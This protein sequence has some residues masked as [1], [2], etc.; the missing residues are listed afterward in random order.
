MKTTT[1]Q[2]N[3]IL[4]L[5]NRTP[6]PFENQ[7]LIKSYN[8]RVQRKAL[9]ECSSFWRT[10]EWKNGRF[11]TERIT[12]WSSNK[13]KKHEIPPTNASPAPLVSTIS[14]WSLTN[15]GKVVTSFS[16]AEGENKTW[17][18]CKPDFEKHNKQWKSKQLKNGPLT[19]NTI[20]WV[21]PDLVYNS[22]CIYCIGIQE[23]NWSSYLLWTLSLITSSLTSFLYL[24][25]SKSGGTTWNTWACGQDEENPAC[26]NQCFL[27]DAERWWSL[28]TGQS[29]LPNTQQKLLHCK[30]QKARE[31]TKIKLRNKKQE[32]V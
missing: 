15:T 7:D 26:Q 20:T 30:T 19:F 22:G 3:G 23:H 9:K 12:G 17:V 29:K 21:K 18:T 14:L 10:V 28:Q 32:P 25:T 13:R 2:H 6:F 1:A 31:L 11:Y 5:S 4:F 16:V 8:F 27:L 24:L